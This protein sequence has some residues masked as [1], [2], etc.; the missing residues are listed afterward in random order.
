MLRALRGEATE[1]PPI[2][3]MRQAG[4]YLPEYRTV[5]AGAGS[6]L[7]LCFNP[8]LA[9]EVSLQPIRRFGLDA[10][11][12]FSDIL[13]VPHGLGQAV[14]F[15][16]GR[17]P[18]LEPVRTNGELACLSLDGMVDRLAPV[19]ET[20]RRLRRSLPAGTALIGFAGAPWTV[21]SY[22]VEG[23]SSRDFAMA[24]GW[25]YGDPAGFAALIDL[26]VEATVAHLLAQIEAGAD[27]VQL[28]DSWA[29]A[30]PAAALQA[31]SIEPCRRIVARLRARHP[32]VPV[33]LFPRGV[34]P[35]YRAYRDLGP[36]ALGLDTGVPL[37][38]AAA[39]LRPAVVLQGNLDPVTLVVGGAALQEQGRAILE[40]LGPDR[41]IVN[42]GHGVLPQTPPDHVA[43]LVE[44]VRGW[45]RPA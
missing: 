38:W 29:G 45:R 24:K 15:S 41:L 33:I 1:R 3:L 20:V 16:E 11:I 27:I 31:W 13:V 25:A 23:G 8:D 5:R 2:W 34:G 22:M 18:I 42:L 12:L 35:A 28:F 10:A 30:L 36:A 9:V 17:G 21:A 4:R 14:G 44:L 6:F 26:L 43:A 32:S 37:D 19:Y 39:E 40:R 7:D